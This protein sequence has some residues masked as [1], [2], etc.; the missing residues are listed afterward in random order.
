MS[1]LIIFIGI[2]MS[3]FLLTACQ[4]KPLPQPEKAIY[5]PYNVKQQHLLAQMRSAGVQ[6]IK[7]GDK[8]ILVIPTDRFFQP[9]TTQ[10][11]HR[12]KKT[13]KAIAEFVKSYASFYARPRIYVYGYTD[14]VFSRKTRRELSKQYA[15][16]VAAY[17]WNSKIPVKWVSVKGFGDQYP[18]ASNRYPAGSV[19]NRRVMIVIK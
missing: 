7:Q 10:L 13:M 4:K 2:L 1:K 3:A 17:L 5:R 6:E 19:Y 16:V 15:K 12:R 8:V 18:I 9:Q 11:K 14:T